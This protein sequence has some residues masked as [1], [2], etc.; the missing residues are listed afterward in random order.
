MCSIVLSPLINSRR[1]PAFFKHYLQLR[2]Q[3]LFPFL[4]KIIIFRINYI[5][6]IHPAAMDSTSRG[7]DFLDN[8]GNNAAAA[9]AVSKSSMSTPV[10]VGIW[11]GA[12]VAAFALAALG[13]AQYRCAWRRYG[14][15]GEGA[16]LM[17]VV[18][19]GGK[20]VCR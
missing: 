11:V 16:G 19:Y 13:F 3:Y 6:N 2:T 1:F 15:E 17:G 12:P 4:T 20:N 9:S 10:S 18:E 7:C 8:I 5:G 14:E